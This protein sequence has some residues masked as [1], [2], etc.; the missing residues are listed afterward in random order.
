MSLLLAGNS[1]FAQTVTFLVPA[2]APETGWTT[3]LQVTADSE[4]HLAYEPSAPNPGYYGMLSFIGWYLSED[5]NINDLSQRFV[6]D[7]T[8][9]YTTNTTYYAIF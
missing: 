6:F 4:G 3:Y 2:Q 5:A 8:T 9:V 7:P 1:I